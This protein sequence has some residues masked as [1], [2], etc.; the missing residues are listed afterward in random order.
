[1]C[2]LAHRRLVIT[3]ALLDGV[4]SSGDGQNTDGHHPCSH[5]EADTRMPLH[6]KLE[7]MFED[8]DY[9]NS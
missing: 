2:F 1:M 8:G 7:L 3:F 6:V 5:E 4:V 9:K